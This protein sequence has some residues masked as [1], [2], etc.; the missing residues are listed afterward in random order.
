MH[1]RHLSRWPATRVLVWG[2]RTSPPAFAAAGARSSPFVAAEGYL[3]ACSRI[4][5]SAVCEMTYPLDIPLASGVLSG[6]ST[7]NHP[8]FA[9]ADGDALNR[10]DV[11][12]GGSERPTTRAWDTTDPVRAPRF[13]PFRSFRAPPQIGDHRIVLRN[14]RF[15]GVASGIVLQPTF[16]SAS[17]NA[18]LPSV[19]ILRVPFVNAMSL[20]SA[21]Q[22]RFG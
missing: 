10:P 6:W 19:T 15:V 7:S 1:S 2:A 16:Y 3:Y 18:L 17:R 13:A 4:V 8:V 5:C 14:R 9:R 20:I 12:P 11:R 21:N 22:R